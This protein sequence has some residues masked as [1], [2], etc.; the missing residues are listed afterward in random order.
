MS[1]YSDDTFEAA[2]SRAV[3]RR[4][5]FDDENYDDD[6]FL[7][8]SQLEF[9]SSVIENYDEDGFE[10]EDDE[11]S[12]V[13]DQPRPVK[14]DSMPVVLSGAFPSPQSSTASTHQTD[15]P[16]VT[17]PYI[18]FLVSQANK[19]RNRQQ[20]RQRN[21]VQRVL[22][23]SE[24]EKETKRKSHLGRCILLPWLVEIAEM[25]KENVDDQKV[26]RIGK[27]HRS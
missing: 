21:S 24:L 18:L 1:Q 6:T 25:N 17:D 27:N 4:G 11:A 26:R 12:P 14:D 10:K 16:E 19:E 7:Q 8:E 23:P 20:Q 22:L 3:S 13:L 5:S 2:S 15:L 9:E